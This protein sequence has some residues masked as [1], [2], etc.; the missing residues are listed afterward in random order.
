LEL[1]F[2]AL[3]AFFRSWFV[4]LA[5][6]ALSLPRLP[7][8]V[9]FIFF[10][11]F[12]QALG[13]LWGFVVIILQVLTRRLVDWLVRSSTAPEEFVG[14]TG[15][16]LLVCRCYVLLAT[17]RVLV[18]TAGGLWT[19][20][21][22]ALNHF[23]TVRRVLER[24]GRRSGAAGSLS[25]NAVLAVPMLM[26]TTAFAICG[27]SPI[28]CARTK[29]S[30]H[31][32]LAEQLWQADGHGNR[33]L[34][35]SL[36]IMMLQWAQL[37]ESLNTIGLVG[38]CQVVPPWRKLVLLLLLP[39]TFARLTHFAWQPADHVFFGNV[40]AELPAV[41]ISRHAA[42]NLLA[43]VWGAW[44]TLAAVFAPINNGREHSEAAS[45]PVGF[46][47]S[48]DGAEKEKAGMDASDEEAIAETWRQLSRR[49]QYTFVISAVSYWVRSFLSPRIGWTFAQ[50][51]VAALCCLYPVMC[52][53]IWS[54]TYMA[55]SLWFSKHKRAVVTFCIV[56]SMIL[57]LRPAV[58]TLVASMHALRQ[59]HKVVGIRSVRYAL[60]PETSDGS[61]VTERNW[62]TGLV[63][64][65]AS[66]LLMWF[67]VLFSLLLLS[68]AQQHLSIYP[69]HMEF[70]ADGPPG[71]S[72]V[73]IVHRSIIGSYLT[74]SRTA[75]S[76]TTAPP[77]TYAVCGQK[78]GG[79]GVLDYSLLSL[80]A[81]WDADSAQLPEVLSHLFPSEMGLAAVVVN[82]SHSVAGATMPWIEVELPQ[83]GTRVVA[84]RGTDP[85]KVADVVEDIMMWTE[86]V[87]LQMLSLVFPTIHAWTGSV[88]DNWVSTTHGFLEALD[89]RAGPWMYEPLVEHLRQ[90]DSQC[91]ADAVSPEAPQPVPKPWHHSRM[92][93]GHSLG[94]AIAQVSAALTGT[95]VVAISP[96]GLLQSFTK[97][98][99]HR[100]GKPGASE[101]GGGGEGGG[102]SND[103]VRAPHRRSVSVV[104]EGDWVSSFD[105]HAGF[106]QTISCNRDDLSVFGNCHLLENTICHLLSECGDPHGRWQ[107]CEHSYEPHLET[108]SLLTSLLLSLPNLA[109]DVAR[110]VS[111][112]FSGHIVIIALCATTAI[113]LLVL[114]RVFG[115]QKHSES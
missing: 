75:G 66:I 64:C 28:L 102:S 60:Q 58:T 80:A 54:A 106:V 63:F 97:H 6:F 26:I 100:G 112:P 11:V 27:M 14:V 24:S 74:L 105:S 7:N 8:I 89:L 83:L 43:T 31:G 69:G 101:T 78:W 25:V 18:L 21:W 1:V 65:G 44:L 107:T 13:L 40:H 52:S 104:V 84:V 9:G 34:R 46:A 81:Y 48:V 95:G 114:E 42:D 45:S 76:A 2:A 17:L 37:F 10:Y 51:D 57:T 35:F 55:T 4:H 77:E 30:C 99:H 94:G 61:R 23:P 67:L 91:S 85:T 32:W 88:T 93:T 113:Q 19:L 110:D 15:A 96:P 22:E 103:R 86:P 59:L 49:F 20:A 38:L 36:V 72:T 41:Q 79:L 109:W 56:V 47:S 108:A 5:D 111:R 3:A 50:N 71:N 39:A 73:R 115:V 29:D 82:G 16:V 98:W 87:V 92:L 53:I 90:V 62:A 33:M 70:H 12:A 68:S